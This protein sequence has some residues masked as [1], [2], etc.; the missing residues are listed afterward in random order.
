MSDFQRFLD[1]F[2]SKIIELDDDSRKILKKL[3]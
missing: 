1:V 3:L 2:K